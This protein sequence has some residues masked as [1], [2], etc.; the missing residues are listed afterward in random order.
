MEDCFLGH[1]LKGKH[2]RLGTRASMFY[3]SV[4]SDGISH[5]TSL[6]LILT[7]YVVNYNGTRRGQAG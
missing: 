5:R 2:D 3:F 7:N 6:N 4:M 1:V